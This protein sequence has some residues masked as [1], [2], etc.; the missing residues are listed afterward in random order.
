MAKFQDALDGKGDITEVARL[1]DSGGSSG[2]T[3]DPGLNG[4][5]LLGD[6]GDLVITTLTCG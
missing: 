2:P 4:E 6:D 3:K 5:V 1:P